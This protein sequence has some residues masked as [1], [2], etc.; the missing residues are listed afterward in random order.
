[1]P[2]RSGKGR[3]GPDLCWLPN[4]C[5]RYSARG[6]QTVEQ[7]AVIASALRDKVW[8]LLDAGKIRPLI[9]AT[10]PLAEAAAAYR[11]ME[12]SQHMGKI[13]LTVEGD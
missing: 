8:P 11:L 6:H 10:L 7:K 2:R 3:S 1:M 4:S 9:H 5:F 13:V 12:S